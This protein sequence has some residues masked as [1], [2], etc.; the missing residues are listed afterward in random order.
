MSQVAPIDFKY[1]FGG[2]DQYYAATNEF[3][4]SL[5]AK[6]GTKGIFADVFRYRVWLTVNDDEEAV[7]SMRAAWYFGCNA[8]ARTDPA[9]ITEKEFPLSEEG[10]AMAVE[11]LQAAYDNA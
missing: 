8:Y 11:W 9:I 2:A 3:T 5:P 7:T 6:N 1:L 10:A 4:G